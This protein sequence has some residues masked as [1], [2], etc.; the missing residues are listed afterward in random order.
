MK[1]SITHW[2]SKWIFI[3]A[4]VGSAAGLGNLWR[5]PFLAYDHGGATFVVA[6]VI[7]NIII[8]IPL[9][10]LEVTMGQKIQRG[11]VDAF[12]H[13]KDVFK[14]IGW[15]TVILG[16]LIVS[17]Y[18]AVVGWGINYFTSSFN[19]G[20]GADT[21]SYFFSN[22]LNLSD[23]V[24]VLGG[25][26][27]SVFTGMLIAWIITYFIIWKGVGSISK[28]VVW[29]ATL[30]FVI[31]AILI[32]RALTLDGAMDGIRYFLIPNWSLLA[33]GQLWLAAFSQTFFSLSLALGVMVT[34]GAYNRENTEIIKSVLWIALGNLTVSI[35]SGFVIFGTLGYMALT[36]GVA[37][38][39][40]VAGGPSLAFVVF[41]K[42]IS[43]LPAFNTL[44][45]VLFFGTLLLLAV[46]SAFSIIEGV[47]RPFQD[48]YPNTQPQKLTFIACFIGF[49]GSIVFTTGAGLYIL[50]IVDHFVLNYGMV[51]VGLLEAIAVGWFY[52]DELTD[53]INKNSDW[54]IGS[55]LNV[56][57]KYLIPLFLI[58]LLVWNI[59]GEIKT[60]YGGYPSWALLW[61]G[62]VPVVLAPVIGYILDRLTTK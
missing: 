58:V 26:S 32:I 27:W 29:T 24:D 3:L 10:T 17:Y 40:V 57:I 38:P 47:V 53:F 41:P 28:V 54:K 59:Y 35:M 45:A 34:Y 49:L 36:Q 56:S 37:L 19:L 22:I 5:F 43:L 16:F 2:P 31:L 11:A 4:A 51:I 13:I 50:D 39:E 55:W 62:V 12:G 1:D 44:I 15:T 48:R 61:L 18:M 9:L 42:A 21:E 8:G 20:W 6:L 7:A 33:D 46:D 52:K 60:P 25:V 14:Y 30:P 23:S